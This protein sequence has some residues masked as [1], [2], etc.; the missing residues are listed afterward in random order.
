MLRQRPIIVRSDAIIFASFTGIPIF[1]STKRFEKHEV[2][3]I[4]IGAE[5]APNGKHMVG[6]TFKRKGQFKVASRA[7]DSSS[8]DDLFTQLERYGFPA[9]IFDPY[10]RTT[11]SRDN[12]EALVS[13]SSI[14]LNGIDTKD[15]YL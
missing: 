11:E 7:I 15:I 1:V 14:G 4:D 5:G 2:Y 10:V 6:V 8:V 3:E 13:R 12:L 9:K